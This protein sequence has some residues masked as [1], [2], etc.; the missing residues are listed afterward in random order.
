MKKIT[1]LVAFAA[2]SLVSFGQA[3]KQLNLGLIGASLE[4]PVAKA[5]TVA[6]AA[7]TNFDLDY[8]TLGV[9]AN[10]YFDDLFGLGNSWDVYGGANLG[11]GLWIGDGPDG[12]SDLDLGLQVGGR[13]FWNDSWGLYVE[14]GGGKLGGAAYGIGVTKVL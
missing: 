12:T 3:K 9:K 8:L 1:L 14:V 6:P 7:F 4:F 5:I 2:F 10:Y 13:W 11:F